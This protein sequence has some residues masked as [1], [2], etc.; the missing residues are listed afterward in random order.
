MSKLKAYF[1]WFI[2]GFTLFFVVNTFRQYWSQI[3]EVKIDLLGFLL[4]TIALIIS[5]IAHIWSAFVWTWIIKSF[6]LKIPFREAIFLY[7]QTNLAKYLPGNVWHFYGRILAIKKA[8]GSLEIASF[9]VILEPILMAIA[10][11]LLALIGGNITT[12]KYYFILQII[13]LLLVLII[14]HPRIINK[15]INFLTLL[16]TKEKPNDNVGITTY[17]WLSLLGEIIYLTT[18]GMGFILTLLAINPVNLEQILP[19]LSAF[20]LA[21]LLG[22]IVPGAPG[23]LGVFEVTIM[24]VLQDNLSGKIV[25]AIALFRLISISAELISL[26]LSWLTKEAKIKL[27]NK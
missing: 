4:L 8:G 3:L 27:L 2:I 13:G 21:W 24:T 22:F 14:I 16:K 9:S 6:Q 25:V 26:L 10:G 23:G 18:R 17:P 7:L 20:S 11:F 1:R 5:T 15:I 12:N 19:L